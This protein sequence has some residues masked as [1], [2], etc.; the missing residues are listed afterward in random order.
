[1]EP[2]ICPSCSSPIVENFNFCPNCGKKFKEPPLSTSISKQMGIYFLSI[3]LPPFGLW[4]GVIYLLDKHEKARM[5]GVI[6]IVLTI[7]SFVFTAWMVYTTMQQLNTLM[8]SQLYLQSPQDL[9]L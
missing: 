6:A 8:G 7:I 9:G 1:M 3:F 4:P 5:I 2:N